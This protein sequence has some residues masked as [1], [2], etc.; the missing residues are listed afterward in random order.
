MVDLLKKKISISDPSFL[1]FLY[2]SFQF[3]TD[4]KQNIDF[5]L[6]VIYKGTISDSVISKLNLI[7]KGKYIL[8]TDIGE[9]N[10]HTPSDYI[11]TLFP[12]LEKKAEQYNNYELDQFIPILKQY[13]IL[14]KKPPLLKEEEAGIYSLF[15]SLV[16]S[17]DLMQKEYFSLLETTSIKRIT[18]SLFTFLLKVKEQNYTGCSDSYKKLINQAY[19][20]FGTKIKAA[21]MQ[22]IESDQKP[23]VGIWFLLDTL[24]R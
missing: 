18:S 21:I 7:T 17:K 3:I 12:A 4:L 15:K 5:E 22:Y 13:Y 24:N 1:Q 16:G 10:L 23:E 19:N 9:I 14:Q 2:P 8:L 6:G 11:K 20:K